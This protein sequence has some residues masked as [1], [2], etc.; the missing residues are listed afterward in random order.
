MSG[1]YFVMS[2]KIEV[3]LERDFSIHS[4]SFLKFIF[5]I[6]DTQFFLYFCCLTRFLVHRKIFYTKWNFKKIIVNFDFVEIFQIGFVEI[7]QKK[8]Q[9]H[10]AGECCDACW[11][12]TWG[13]GGGGDPGVKAWGCLSLYQRLPHCN[14]TS[15]FFHFLA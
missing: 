5:M 4:T 14:L 6:L 1:I 8:P 10:N 13:C 3:G 7:F 12:W 9:K 15:F 11:I 2:F